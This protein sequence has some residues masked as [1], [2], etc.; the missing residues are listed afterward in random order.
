MYIS[1]QVQQMF[2]TRKKGKREGGKVREK[3]EREGV[4]E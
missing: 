4:K 3:E 1:V 2:Y